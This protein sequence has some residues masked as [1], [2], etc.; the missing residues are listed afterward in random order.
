MKRRDFLLAISGSVATAAAS[1]HSAQ[2]AMQSYATTG[3]STPH[4]APNQAIIT[5]TAQFFTQSYRGLQPTIDNTGRL[6]IGDSLWNIGRLKSLPQ[7]ESLF[8]IECSGNAVGGDLIGTAAWQGIRF[9]D[10]LNQCHIPPNAT[11]AKF[12]S[13]DGYQTA[14][15]LAALRHPEALLA[16]A[17][18]GDPLSLEHGYPLRLLLPGA[19]GHKMPKWIMHIEFIDYEFLGFWESRGWSNTAEIPT[20][21]IILSPSAQSPAVRGENLIISGIAHSQHE[22]TAVEVSIDGG[23][24]LPTALFQPAPNTWTQW[25]L[26]WTPP[27]SGHL[28]IAARATDAVGFTQ[29]Q[30]SSGRFSDLSAIHQITFEVQA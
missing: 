5:P 19:T 24:W 17:M 13:A 6:V 27:A 2:A 28:S 25:W 14:V 15:S 30:A 11:H 3:R 7:V 21:A 20:H 26:A 18:N 23:P 1:P 29:S 16:Y 8:T 12:T 22:I 9:V 4:I 10:L